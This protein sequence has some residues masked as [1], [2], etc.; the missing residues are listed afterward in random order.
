MNEISEVT[1]GRPRDISIDQRVIAATRAILAEEGFSAATIHAVARRADIRP[2]SIYRR[3]P[4]RIEMIEEAIFPGLDHLDVEPTGNLRDD[5]QRFV[6]AYKETFSSPI[7]LAALPG[8]V[9]EYHS[10]SPS[11]GTVERAWRSARPL[12]RAI[13][14]AAPVGSVD[15]SL[16][17]DDIFD[18]IV[19]GVLYKIHAAS[20]GP[21]TDAPD[22]TVDLILRTLRG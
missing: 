14:V 2:A 17:P 22:K 20:L 18:L 3:W 4:S 19:G 15:P 1:K 13:L 21:R 16:N 5:L 7:A 11:D 12:F 6:D 10:N 8:L 9:A